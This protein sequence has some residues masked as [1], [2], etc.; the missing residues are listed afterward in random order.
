MPAMP[1][2]ATSTPSG[3]SRPASRRATS[4]PNPSSERK[5]LPTPATSTPFTA[6][7]HSTEHLDLVGVEVSEAPVGDLELGGGVAVDGNRDVHLAVDVVQHRVHGGG[8]AV[9]E[10]VLDVA[11][12]TGPQQHPAALRDGGAADE[13]GVGLGI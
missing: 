4:T 2:S 12:G 13:D 8:Q 7:I 1:T 9:E 3:S 11:A 6:E 10:A 5:T